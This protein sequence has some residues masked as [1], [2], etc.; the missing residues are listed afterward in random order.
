MK[1]VT[2]TLILSLSLFADLE[3]DYEKGEKIY[4]SKSCNSC[5]GPS[6][7]GLHK[8]PKLANV[9]KYKL[10]AKLKKYQKKSGVL[11]SEAQIMIPY[12]D[13]INVIE[14]D[15][16]TTYL[17]EFKQKKNETDYDDSWDNW[18]DGGS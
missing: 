2:L 9:A 1:T 18:G 8:F 17:S 10:V 13:S 6:A 14:I 7:E 3:S 16:V 12:A 4:F 11:S 15:L 5:H